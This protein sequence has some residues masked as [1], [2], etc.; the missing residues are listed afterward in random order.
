MYFQFT[1][2]VQGIQSRHSGLN[3][4]QGVII[5]LWLRYSNFILILCACWI[6][7]NRMAS[8]KMNFSIKDFLIKCD[9]ICGKL[10]IWS[11]LK[12]LNEKLHFCA[13][14]V[15]TDEKIL[16]FENFSLRLFL[17]TRLSITKKIMLNVI[18]EN[19]VK[20]NGNTTTSKK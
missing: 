5:T 3:K 18:I 4:R 13:E 6:C 19:I 16:G 11:H 10:W 2:C 15:I 9:Q 7:G 1:S 14:R 8:Q 17:I 20:N 12:I